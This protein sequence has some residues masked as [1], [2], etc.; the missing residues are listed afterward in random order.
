M[1]AAVLGA[2]SSGQSLVIVSARYSSTKPKKKRKKETKVASAL[3]TINKRGMMEWAAI[4][5][6]PKC[7]LKK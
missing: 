2:V 1:K 5:E 6:K 7:F 4:M 3:A